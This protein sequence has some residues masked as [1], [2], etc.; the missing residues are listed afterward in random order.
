M[1]DIQEIRTVY[2]QSAN[3]EHAKS[4]QDYVRGKFKFFGIKA[5]L[6]RE[7]SKPFIGEV[8]NSTR[9]EVFDL[10]K[11]LWNQ[12]ER[13]LHHLGQEIL[14]RA[15]KHLDEKEDIEFLQWMVLNNSWWD[16]VDYIAPKLMKEYF[17][18][19][20]EMRNKKVDE[21]VASDNIWLKR[22]ALLIHLK[23]K[24]NPDLPYLF[25][26]ILRLTGSK[27]FFINKAIGWVLRE[28]AKKR[29]EIIY[30]FVKKHEKSLSNLSV[31][32]ALKHSPS[33]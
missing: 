21:W 17:E 28:H 8:K 22:S 24:E 32:E 10:V 27:E 19:F 15:K 1:Q 6:R 25:E 9:E 31:K 4:M 3:P 16:T 33:K 18:K 11:S 12:P 13:E 2:Q 20:P 29:P 23:Q 26:T 7:I 5:P 14:F 30:N